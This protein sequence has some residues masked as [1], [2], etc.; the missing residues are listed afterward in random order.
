MPRI[1]PSAVNQEQ[2]RLV[3][4]VTAPHTV[5]TTMPIRGLYFWD[6][7]RV[8]PASTRLRLG[9]QSLHACS[10]FLCVLPSR[11]VTLFGGSSFDYSASEAS[12]TASED[13]RKIAEVDGTLLL[14]S[15]LSKKFTAL[16]SSCVTELTC[17]SMCAGVAFSQQL[18]FDNL[19]SPH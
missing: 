7:L 8:L 10:S 15:G 4:V 6:V 17:L 19:P 14:K 13:C 2:V 18:L 16:C 12:R 5:V 3:A 9:K 11:L 1:A